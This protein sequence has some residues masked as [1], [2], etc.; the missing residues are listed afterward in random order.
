MTR[1]TAFDSFTG[2]LVDTTL[3]GANFELI[4][5]LNLK[6]QD[7]CEE[8][9]GAQWRDPYC[10]RIFR[11]YENPPKCKYPNGPI[12]DDG[13][14]TCE[15]AAATELDYDKIDDYG[16][17]IAEYVDR[18]VECAE[19]GNQE[20]DLLALPIDGSLPVCWYNMPVKAGYL[21]WTAIGRTGTKQLAQLEDFP[22][23]K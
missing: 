6:T 16:L 3:Q 21:G 12:D 22:P 7:D 20:V 15:W 1:Q 2:K 13:V 18:L 19:Q 11:H 17:K 4:A 9:Y 5:D 23:V 8:W 10:W 14:S